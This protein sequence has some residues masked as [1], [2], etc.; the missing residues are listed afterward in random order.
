MS[1]E[2]FRY[3]D[4]S[5]KQFFIKENNRIQLTEY[6]KNLLLYASFDSLI[7]ADYY[8]TSR[9]AYI[10]GTV[11]NENWG[12]FSQHAYIQDDG[13]IR[14]EKDN[15]QDL[16]QEGS[17]QFRINTKFNTG[18][19]YQ[20]FSETEAPTIPLFPKIDKEINKFGDGSLNLTGGY[21]KYISYNASNLSSMVMQGTINFFFKTNYIGVPV[22]DTFIFNL[23]NNDDKSNAIEIFHETSGNLKVVIYNDSNEIGVELSFP[24]NADSQWHE[25][26]LDFDLLEGNNHLF[27]DGTEYAHNS[28]TCT[29]VPFE[30]DMILGGENAD[31]YLDDL[32]IFNIIKHT[33]NY[34]AR[35]LPIEEEETLIVLA[36][37]D[38]LFNLNVGSLPSILSLYP[39]SNTFGFKI[40]VENEYLNEGNDIDIVLSAT[41]TTLQDI[42]NK[43]YAKLNT[44][45][46]S[47]V[48]VVLEDG[49]IT[50]KT[51]TL[52]ETILLENP[53]N[54]L[55]LLTILGI[56]NATI[57]NPPNENVN[58]LD[59]Y[60][61]N[62]NANRIT[63]THATNGH[64]MLKMYD[65]NEEK[66]IDKDLGLWENES[67]TW[68]AFELF[69]NN[70]ITEL[71]INGNLFE[72]AKTNFSRIGGQYLYFYGG[73][74]SPYGYDEVIV[75]NVQQNASNYVV[76][77][78][79]LTKYTTSNPYIDI[80]FG[81]SF[82]EQTV[83]DL[84]LNCSSNVYFVVKQGNI[85]KYYYA[86]DWQISDGSY[87]QS[88]SPSNMET[89]FADLTFTDGEELII[90]AY[91]NSDGITLS[92]LDDITIN[93]EF[94]EDNTAIITGTIPLF[95]P[96][97]LSSN[98]SVVITTDKDSKEINLSSEAIDPT[99][100]SLA[101]I[102]AAINI[103]NV[104]GLA[105][106]GDNG[107]GILVLQ[108]TTGGSD[109]F[110]SITEG[111]TNNA[112][113]IVWGYEASDIGEQ[114]VGKYFDY[115][116]IY[117]WIR[118]QLGAPTVPVELT[119]EQLE[120]CVGAAVYWY[121]YYRNAKE[122][123]LQVNLNG[124]SEEGFE[125]PQEVG[126][127]DNIIEIIMK[128]RFP[129]TYYAGRSDI[130]GQI[131]L[132][133][134]FMQQQG[135]LRNMIGDYYLTM[136]AQ[137]DINNIMGT[138]PSWH[139]Y[140]GKIF[141]HPKP[142]VFMKVG[143]RFRSAVSINEINTNIIIKGYALAK[144]KT[145]LGTIR[146]TF[147]SSIPGGSEMIS[148]RGE[149]LIAE[150]KEEME[151]TIATIKSLSEPLGFTWG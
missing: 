21:E 27:I 1:T 71:F 141:I 26:E 87:S 148:L 98:Y 57:V 102:K 74:T 116:E 128:P 91:F 25:F 44:L 89:K 35:T 106:V 131:Y 39:T 2:T 97:D 31:F 64:L 94:Y 109:A 17:I 10:T 139:F 77:S 46:I 3:I 61:A 23:K 124:T 146:S 52:G 137:Q 96:V 20:K 79:A 140:N 129:F 8:Q 88:C 82:S 69:W 62:N 78:V 114:S 4:Y 92:W 56:E 103:A 113:D 118:A 59:I 117:R 81:S 50:I 34:I 73:A 51:T 86:G 143:I 105:P 120:D 121:N 125:I 133:W 132:Q 12:A 42:V 48:E 85:W 55:S 30:G 101:E 37:F 54:S 5:D 126:G 122:N 123:I 29:R 107:S 84:N 119:D 99:A 24:W 100:V 108:T 13:Y 33:N 22:E 150:G 49:K 104:E 43:I 149:A 138:N 110:I 65:N 15:F 38:S 11:T 83:K 19:G 9:D 111:V 72:I 135:G 41:D 90:R 76:P 63:L 32:A 67:Y 70:S 130:I 14:F 95:T 93:M 115:S 75:S 58:I 151:Q 145:I 112:L 80:S 142:S 144:A 16:A 127:E 136:S 18:Y 40:L 45:N 60:N 28:F 147:G 7:K 134:F 66:K 47:N 36:K 6:Q 68:N 53:V